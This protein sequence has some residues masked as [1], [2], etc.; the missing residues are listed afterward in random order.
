MTD[1]LADLFAY[2]I[3]FGG[4]KAFGNRERLIRLKTP[5]EIEADRREAERIAKLP[6]QERRQIMQEKYFTARLILSGIYLLLHFLI[7]DI[8]FMHRYTNGTLYD[9]PWSFLI[10]VF[11]VP[12]A[13]VAV[14][15]LFMRPPKEKS[16]RKRLG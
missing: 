8:V 3:V 13:V 11:V 5:A 10:F 15:C 6:E 4:A 9:H 12:I 16:T 1:F 14:I 2:S 7:A